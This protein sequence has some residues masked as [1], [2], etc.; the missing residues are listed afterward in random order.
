MSIGLFVYIT[1]WENATS[2]LFDP[3]PASGAIDT[4]KLL[5]SIMIMLTYPL[6]FFSCREMIIIALPYSDQSRNNYLGSMDEE[7]ALLYPTPDSKQQNKAFWMMPGEDK[8]LTRPFHIILT[9][10]LWGVTTVLAIV[11]PSLGDVLNLVGCATGTLIAFILP[12]MFSFR[13]EGY[14][15]IAALI[16]TV[17]GVIGG[18]GTVLSF[19]QLV[20]DAVQR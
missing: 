13:L 7:Q 14:S 17:G 16:L 9:V 4:A 15:H 18:F 10:L 11:A 19:N 20:S 1:F 3:Y 5:L 2:A 8:Q 12:A 6:A